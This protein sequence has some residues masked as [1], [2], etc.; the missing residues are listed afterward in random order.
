MQLSLPCSAVSDRRIDMYRP[1]TSRLLHQTDA[2]SGAMSAV[3]V[4]MLVGAGGVVLSSRDGR[5]CNS[6]VGWEER[7]V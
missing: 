2:V 7:L 6:A 5:R 4:L 3:K 1:R